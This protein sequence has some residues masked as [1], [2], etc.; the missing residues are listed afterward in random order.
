M[1]IP[2]CLVCDSTNASTLHQLPNWRVLQCTD[3][4]H[5]YIH[6]LPSRQ[7]LIDDAESAH[8]IDGKEEIQ[9]YFLTRHLDNL[10]DPVIVEFTK[11]LRLL[12]NSTE[13]RRLLDIGAGDGTFAALAVQ[14]GWNVVALD[15]STNAEKHA[16]EAYGLAIL[17]D[18]FPSQTLYT[19]ERF[20]VI[21]MLDFLEHVVNPR[22]TVV[23]ASKLLQEHGI[24][25]VN[26]PNHRSLLCWAIDIAGRIP[27]RSIQ[28]LLEKY[29]CFAHISI[30]EPSSL[31]TLLKNGGFS[32][33]KVGLNN[34]ILGRFVLPILLKLLIGLLLSLAQLL[35]LQSRV[36]VLAKA[37]SNSNN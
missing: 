18:H 24:L 36:W 23:E 13:G 12:E 33:E 28:I 16:R 11:V 37:T 22:E 29:Y 5:L 6:P 2:L 35:K 15:F 31:V 20:D 4:S 19:H 17:T 26:S 30:F 34:P 10:K 7:Q 1:S 14:R 3:C 9:E 8:S 27:L 32:I 25:Y 21:T